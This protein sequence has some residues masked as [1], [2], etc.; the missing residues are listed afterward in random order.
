MQPGGGNLAMGRYEV[1]RGSTRRSCGRR[2][3]WA[4]HVISVLAIGETLASSRRI[5]IPWCARA[6]MTRRPMCGGWVAPPPARIVCRARR[7]GRGPRRVRPGG[8]KRMFGAAGVRM[9]GPRRRRSVRIPRMAPGCS[10]WWATCGSGPGTAGKVI[11]TVV[12]FAGVPGSTPARSIAVP[13]RA[14]GSAPAIGTGCGSSSST[15]FSPVHRHFRSRT[16]SF[17][18]IFARGQNSGQCPPASF[19]PPARSDHGAWGASVCLLRPAPCGVPL[20][21]R[22]A[23]WYGVVGR[24]MPLR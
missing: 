21:I 22:A 16:V 24:E 13:A 11:A 10:T 19:R 23:F 18:F 4:A 9:F 8:V 5:G 7:N 6:G 1:T 2:A 14:T 15:V 3:T 17:L 20:D 12:W